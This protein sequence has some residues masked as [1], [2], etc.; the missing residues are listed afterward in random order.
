[1]WQIFATWQPKKRVGESNKGIF[2][3]IF[4]KI[5]HISREKNLK[6][7]ILDNVFD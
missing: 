3:I 6:S 4:L 5:R 7:P 2:E 1:L